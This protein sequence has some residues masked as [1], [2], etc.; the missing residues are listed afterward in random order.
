M[1]INMLD[2]KT[3][4]RIHFIP[5]S[6]HDYAWTCPRSW[7]IQRYLEGFHRATEM[8]D[9]IPNYSWIIDN[10]QHSWIPT[11]IY[12]PDLAEK[13]A[14]HVK[15]GK[16]SILDGGYS[17]ARPSQTCEETYIRNLIA[18]RKFFQKRFGIDDIPVL[19]NADT[20][21]G[22]SQMP[23]IAK[24]SG[25][26]YYRFLRNDA[27]L[28]HKGI[29]LQFT[30]KGLDGSEVLVTRGEYGGMW[31]NNEWLDKDFD[32]QWDEV[33][34]GFFD[35]CLRDKVL[36]SNPTEDVIVFIG[37]DD[38]L[39]MHDREDKP[40]KI[41]EFIVAWNEREPV[42]IDFTK[43]DT[44]FEELNR[45]N[46]PE[47]EG[48]LDHN[49]LSYE[50]TFGGS[51]T[52]MWRM[53]LE[54][55]RLM[56]RLERIAAI[57][58]ELGWDYPEQEITDCW[59]ALFEITGHAIEVVIDKDFKNLYSLALRGFKTAEKL[60]NDAEN[61]ISHAVPHVEDIQ[62]V[63]I[64]PLNWDVKQTVKFEVSSYDGLNGFD[65]VDCQGKKYEY[66]IIDFDSIYSGTK[67]GSLDVVAEVTV[68]A[69]GITCLYMIPN[70]TSLSKKINETFID[71]IPA[72]LPD[73]CCDRIE[74]DNSRLKV[75]FYKGRLVY[76]S[77]SLTG[78]TISAEPDREL[79]NLIFRQL[80]PE[81]SWLSNFYSWHKDHDFLPHHAKVLANGPIRYKYRA[82][83]T[84][85]GQDAAVT[86]T[87]DKNKPGI[88]IDV[89]TNFRDEIE[90][91]LLFA[92]S[93]DT[94]GEIYAD[95]PFG[96][97]KRELFYDMTT[98]PALTCD[99]SFLGQIYGRNW[100]SF[101]LNK[102]PVSIISRNCNVYYI[103]EKEN[104]TMSLVLARHLPL[105]TRTDR[106][107]G[108]CQEGLSGCGKNHYSFSLMMND[109][110]GK[111]TDIQHY[112]KECVY[113]V[114]SKK[115]YGRPD[116]NPA[117]KEYSFLSV[118]EENIIGTALYKEKSKLYARFFE[119]NG[120]AV[121][122]HITVPERIT[123]AR[124]IDFEGNELDIG[125]RFD[126]ASNVM[127]VPFG[128]Y[129]IVT[130]EME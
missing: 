25:H 88:E 76:I 122:A 4:K 78:R 69:S 84:I 9:Q 87:L 52:S 57:A 124:T 38:C 46:L 92:M 89:E 55:D 47:Y 74:F 93:S 62:T 29:P 51:D 116:K 130:I 59:L 26:R 6:H 19:F 101:G 128:K 80:P 22:H 21:C 118:R 18:G 12:C 108:K 126:V 24:L 91:M 107:F 30:W 48:V 8:V 20:A 53:R 82:Y 45:K 106:C 3:V 56:V 60:L 15:S 17:L 61:Y 64:N 73:N 28:T 58:S 41:P 14:G 34:Q 123:Q 10:V 39:P 90:G 37:S 77:D 109:E 36:E 68:P 121:E 79:I 1:S 119:C 117:K 104:R 102:V 72:C 65:V 120:D 5:Y 70:G 105:G 67:Y 97:E 43:L 50:M 115:I 95:I 7:H 75:V 96:T 40:L 16:F 31:Y 98:P 125:A 94:D 13:I 54:Y 83:G 35:T 27:L 110:I 111:S 63:L 81:T 127:T 129:Q 100:C 2:G 23:Q 66:Q 114:S 32:T 112:H 99:I 42:K 113:P 33:R 44:V 11:E 49:E 86:Y 85:A 103:L 71:N